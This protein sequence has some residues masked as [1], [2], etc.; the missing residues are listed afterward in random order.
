MNYWV[1]SSLAFVLASSARRRSLDDVPRETNDR[2]RTICLPVIKLF[3]VKHDIRD[4]E[5]TYLFHGYL[6]ILSQL[7]ALI[8]IYA[9]N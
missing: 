4:L 1:K 5:D 8:L 3:H 9:T 6:A 7:K 2:Y